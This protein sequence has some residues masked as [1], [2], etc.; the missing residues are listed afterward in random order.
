MEFRD[1]SDGEWRGYKASYSFLGL[2]LEG[3]GSLIGW[4]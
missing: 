2:V 1:L 4:L 3:L